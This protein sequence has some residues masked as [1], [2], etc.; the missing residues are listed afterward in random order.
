[1]YDTVYKLAKNVG[2]I[3][4]SRFEFQLPTYYCAALDTFLYLSVLQFLLFL[5]R[6]NVSAS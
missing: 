2:S 4:R 6:E 5:N 3:V 1:M